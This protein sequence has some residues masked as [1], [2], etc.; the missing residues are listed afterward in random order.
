MLV[1]NAILS[2]YATFSHTM[3]SVRGTESQESINSKLHQMTIVAYISLTLSVILTVIFLLFTIATLAVYCK[4]RQC[5]TKPDSKLA[6]PHHAQDQAEPVYEDMLEHNNTDTK[7]IKMKI[8][9][10]YKRP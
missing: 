1:V 5:Y 10:L 9:I 3:V 2:N 7:D 8:N 6:S 4:F